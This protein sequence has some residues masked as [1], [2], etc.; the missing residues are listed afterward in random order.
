VSVP[1][2]VRKL[3]AS[4]IEAQNGNV[5]YNLSKS[6]HKDDDQKANKNL[7]EEIRKYADGS[8]DTELVDCRNVRVHANQQEELHADQGL[9]QRHDCKGK[10]LGEGYD[11][12][13]GSTNE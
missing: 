13:Y 8:N 11:E 10:T 4:D 7:K 5:E 6:I 12:E 2:D 3:H 1:R 9:D